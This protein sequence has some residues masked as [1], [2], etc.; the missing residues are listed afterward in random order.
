LRE[1]AALRRGAHAPRGDRAMRLRRLLPLALGLACAAPAR[2]TTVTFRQGDAGYA[3]TYDT[4]VSQNAPNG[5]S[6]DDLTLLRFDGIIGSGAGQVPSGAQ[7]TSATLTYY[8]SD[9]GDTAEIHYAAAA[10]TES[11]TFNSYCGAGCDATQIGALVGSASAPALG[12][13]TADVTSSIQAWANGAQNL[14]W[15]FVPTGPGGAEASSSENAN[16]VNRPLLTVVYGEG[17]PPSNVVREPYL[18]L[19]TSTSVTVVWSTE[20]ATDSVV[21]Y[22]TSQG[23]L[24]R[25]ASVASVATNHVVSVSGLVPATRY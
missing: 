9:T 23:V 16:Q 5:N 1:G 22:G 12:V 8:V 20:S 17:P 18:Q 6:K 24:D 21:H 4:F 10:W 13:T 2:A 15:I 14:G 25:T 3:S 11:S 19:A 7:I